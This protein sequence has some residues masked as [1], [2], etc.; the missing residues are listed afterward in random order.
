METG[1]NRADTAARA[2]AKA[3]QLF[4]ITMRGNFAA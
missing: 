3:R 1:G 2:I 4:S